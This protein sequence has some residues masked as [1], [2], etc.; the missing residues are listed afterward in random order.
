V[1]SLLTNH[2]SGRRFAPPL[3][4]ICY[5]TTRPLRRDAFVKLAIFDVDGTLLNN[6]ACE[7]ACFTQAL[8]EVLVLPALNDD[9]AT[10]RDVSDAGIA[11]E[12]YRLVYG[13]DP[14]PALLEATITRFVE[15]LGLAHRAEQIAQV[16][17]AEHLFSA[18]RLNGW[19]VAIATGAWHGAA[20]FK[21]AAAAFS[22][23][24]VPIATAEDGPARTSIVRRAH[25]RAEIAYHISPFERVVSIGD[26]VWD[27]HAA[28]A[29]GIPFVGVGDG[30]RADR[31][32]AAG[33][34]IILKDFVD[35][36]ETLAALQNAGEPLSTVP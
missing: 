24:S 21:L 20:A 8:S 36:S 30:I 26:G 28:Q 12:A 23:E 10:Y 25:I 3:N 18:L 34:S 29:L 27:A 14:T 32:R 35:I 1:V 13:I 16:A 31:L 11:T 22:Y 6:Q 2:C 33:A 9:W 17:G 7:D 5:G 15:L 19:A 4:S